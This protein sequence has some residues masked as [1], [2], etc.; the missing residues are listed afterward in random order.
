MAKGISL[1][2][3]LNSV[4]PKHYGG[5]DGQLNG[6]ENDAN[7]MAD[8]AATANLDVKKLLT[9]DAT[10]NNVKSSMNIAAQA[11]EPNDFFFLSYAGHGSQVPDLNNDEV[12]YLDE[13]WCLYDRQFLDD[14]YYYYLSKFREGVRILVFI[15]SCHAGTAV[16]GI[17]KNFEIDKFNSNV[18]KRGNKYRFVP[19]YVEDRTYHLHKDMYDKIQLNDELD[20]TKNKVIS[21]TIIISGCVDNELSQDGTYNGYFTSC[22]KKIWDYGKFDG[23]YKNFH[24]SIYNLMM[25]SD[26]HPMYITVGKRDQIFENQKPFTI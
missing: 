20:N 17:N 2:I 19:D 3:G 13:T 26:Q 12:D 23:S 4:D 22:L 5:W 7:D 9:K 18:D 10:V 16:K 21:S 24:K 1:N 11:L 14:E 6:C 15:D 25:A 8:I